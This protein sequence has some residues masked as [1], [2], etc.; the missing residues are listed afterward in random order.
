MERHLARL[1]SARNSRSTR[2][3]ETSTIDYSRLLRVARRLQMK[4]AWDTALFVGRLVEHQ[5]ACNVGRSSRKRPATSRAHLSIA[6]V[7]KR[8][9]SARAWPPSRR[10]KNTFQQ[11]TEVNQGNLEAPGE[12]RK[13]PVEYLTRLDRYMFHRNTVS[14]YE[15][16]LCLTSGAGGVAVSFRLSLS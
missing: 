15:R 14:I 3:S 8:S 1:D 2:A 11:I 10:R 12:D 9:A 6:L 16:A 7:S 4:C 13:S 5:S